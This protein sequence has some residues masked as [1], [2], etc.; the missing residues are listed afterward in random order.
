MRLFR[1]GRFGFTLIELLV[2][3]AIIAILIALLLPAVQQAREAARRTQCRNNLKQL[4]LALHNY[5]STFNFFP[6]ANYYSAQDSTGYRSSGVLTMLLPYFDQ[7]PI[8]NQLNFNNR[9]NDQ[10]PNNT[11]K[12][13][14]IPGLRC[15][16]ERDYPGTEPGN[17]YVFSGGPSL[18]MISPNPAVG[19]GGPPG[20]Q[21]GFNDQIGMFNMRRAINF[22]DVLDG[23]SNAIAASE[24][25]FG[26]NNANVFSGIVNG[27]STLPTDLV[28][29]IAFPAGMTNTFAP[30]AV[31]DSYGVSCIAA[32]AAPAAANHHSSTHREWINGQPGQ[33][34]FNTLNNPNSSNPDCHEC[35]NCS[36]YDSRGV[37]TARSRHT[38]GVTVLMGDG[39][40]R[41]TSDNVDNNIWQG[42]GGIA[43]G[44]VLGEF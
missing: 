12:N 42:A 36:W 32:V 11:I 3:I 4:G 5:H 10:A 29:G 28:R 33:T 15:P 1:R 13:N 21:I 41:F 39:A 19:I 40:V 37:W 7:A 9:M 38:G 23:T 20:T 17:N 31:L 18:F 2:V 44:R 30:K 16:S 8:Y 24:A 6:C 22:R 35:T 43:D 25:L 34:I 27:K 26:D 14:K